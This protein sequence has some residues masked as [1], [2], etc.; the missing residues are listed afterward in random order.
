MKS[1]RILTLTVLSSLLVLPAYGQVATGEIAGTVTD[2]T[3]A[4]VPNAK[5]AATNAAT[6]TVARETISGGDG[7]YIITLLPPGTYNLSV[8]ASGF[9]KVLQNGVLLQTNQRAKI[10]FALQVGQVQETIE[11]AAAAPLLESQS[12]S[13]GAVIN[14]QFVSELPLNGRNFVQLA[15]LSPGVNGTGYSTAGTIQS[16]TRPDD[17]RPGTEIFSN[18][19]REGSNNFLYDGADNN[20]RLIGLITLRPAIEAIREFKVQTNL[21]SADTGRNSG[22]VVDVITKSGTNGIHGAAFEFLRNS[23]MDARNFFNA[24]G[25]PFPSFKYNQFGGAIGGPA[26]KNKT[27]WF[28]DYEGFRRSLQQ[29]LTTTIPTAAIKRGDFSAENRIYDPLT[30]RQ[31]GAVFR[32]DPFANNQIPANRF[33]PVTARL[34]AAYPGTTNGNLTNNY[35]TNLAQVQNW[36]Q[37]DIRV[38]HQFSPNDNFFVRW[39]AQKTETIAP[40]TFPKVQIQGLAKEVGVGNED[41]FAGPASNPVQHAVLSYTKV[42]SPR[43]VNDFRFGYNRFVLDYTQA[44]AAP[45]DNLANALGVRNGNS[46]P[47]QYALPIINNSNYAGV[48]HSRSLPIYRRSNTFHYQDNVTFTAGAHTLKFGGG[49]YRR[50]ITEYQTNR[51]N[52]RF[53]FNAAFT[54]SRG[55][56]AGPSGNAMASFILG[57]PTLIEQDYTLAW[58]GQRLIETGFYFA[59]DWR[60]SRKLTLNL[61][62]RHDYFSPVTEVADRLANFDPATATVL[63]ANRDGVDRRMGVKRNFKDWAPR[64]GFAYQALSHTVIRGGYGIFYN[65]SGNGGAALRLFR[66]VPFGPIYN[67]TPG[68]FNVGP[69]VSDGFPAPPTVNFES[70]KNPSGGVIGVSSDFRSSYAQQFNLSIQ[71]EIAPWQ[72]IFKVAYVG[73]VGRRLH[74]SIDL[75][76]P[77]AGP[78][79]VANRRAFFGVRPA[80]AQATYAVSDTNSNYNAFQLTFEKRMSHGLSVLLGYTWAH[81]IDNVATEFG[82]GTG[83]PQDIRCRSCERGNSNYD[84]RHRMTVSYTYALPVLRDARGITRTLI[85][86]WQLNGITTMQTGLPF[87]PGL[88]VANTNGAGG[89]R[90]DSLGR[91]AVLPADQRSLARWF[92]PTAFAG[93]T[94]IR[95]GNAG[96]N[97]LFGPGRINFDMSLFKDF[98]FTENWKLQFRSEAFNL[99][100]TPQF[101]LP[102]ASIGDANAGRITSTVGNPRQLQLALRLQF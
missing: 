7:G 45:G 56:V 12:S 38:D 8:E 100:N 75:N 26:I 93:P 87:T 86:G 77:L 14:Q 92:D 43:M 59:D 60:V 52:G 49:V 21:Y 24:K 3:G 54:D 6:N 98:A 89:S 57:Y 94:T 82:G 48:G 69:R 81:A 65:P 9:R 31:D 71:H 84:L 46:H 78:G 25:T 91:T 15:I 99:F 70:A 64:F 53:N 22:A 51:G 2:S 30:G 62:V 19:N 95:F 79:A 40:Y 23:A 18:G 5:V 74:T 41:T 32:R 101:G 67:V 90:P 68:D 73:N 1:I 33:D 39:S 4:A 72:A 76:Q 37:Y 66:H 102:N 97:I 34:L 44:D 96:R 28:F 83:T 17:R 88:L 11:V 13:L 29:F 61:G 58:T 85:G 10:D 35:Q 80:L 27:F 42:L 63:I 47:L 16:G 20:E 50:Q 55:S 36:D